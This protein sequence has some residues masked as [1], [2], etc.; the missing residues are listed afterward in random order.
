MRSGELARG[1]YN[2]ACPNSHPHLFPIT[3]QM[4]DPLD[5]S[6]VTE[7]EMEAMLTFAARTGDLEKLQEWGRQGVR[8]VTAQ[9]LISAALEGFPEVT[10]CLVQELGADVSQTHDGDTP[11][12]IAAK[13]GFSDLVRLLV[14]EFGADINQVCSYINHGI[15]DV[16]TPL[17]MAAHEGHLS[18]VR[19]LVELGAEVKAAASEGYT[20]LLV[21]ALGGVT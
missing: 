8:V 14:T 12:A 17:S 16:G 4:A 9:P 6:E 19:R 20:A 21:S 11:L 7:E 10:R 18:V 3:P 5:L 13:E 1:N 15:D 2:Y